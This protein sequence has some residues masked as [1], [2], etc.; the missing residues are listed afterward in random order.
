MKKSRRWHV[1]D[2]QLGATLVAA[3]AAHKIVIDGNM[4]DWSSLA[5]HTDPAGD[6][7][8]TDH[9]ARDD[10]PRPVNHPDVDLLEYKVSHD[11]ENLYVYLRSKGTIARTQ[12]S[13]DGVPG[14]YYVV[15][16]IDVDDND[17]TGYWISEGG[18]YPTTRGYDVNAEV[19]FFDGELNTVCYLNHGAL[20]AAELHQ[21]F[22]DQSLG[23]YQEGNDGPYP[24]GFMKI[25]PGSLRPIH[26]MGLS[27]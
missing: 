1:F 27:R 22:L 10:T 12:R 9:I 15:V 19:E 7:H 26:A 18:Y 24:V 25:L 6:T 13:A 17:E 3:P 21:A 4:E 14:R 2:Q 20:D 16:T 11:A 8:D 5:S 23:K